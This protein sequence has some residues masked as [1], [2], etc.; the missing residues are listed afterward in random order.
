LFGKT[1][2]TVVFLQSVEEV[3]V[4][5]AGA[6][7]SDDLPVQFSQRGVG[8][9]EGLSPPLAADGLSGPPPRRDDLVQARNVLGEHVHGR[10]VG[11]VKADAPLL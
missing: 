5:L 1:E 4:P 2:A 8:L 7:G 9:V 11:V 3:E 6:V 10:V